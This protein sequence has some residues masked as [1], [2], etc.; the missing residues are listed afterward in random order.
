MATTKEFTGTWD[1]LLPYIYHS[2]TENCREAAELLKKKF[3]VVSFVLCHLFYSV[4]RG[5]TLSKRQLLILLCN[6]Y[7]SLMLL[8]KY[9]LCECIA[10][11]CLCSDFFWFEIC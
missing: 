10:F 4:L 9:F 7:K 2:L 1:S 11:N 8:L 3:H 6:V 5:F